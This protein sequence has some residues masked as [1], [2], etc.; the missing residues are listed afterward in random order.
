MARSSTSSFFIATFLLRFL[1]ASLPRLILNERTG[2]AMDFYLQ[3]LKEQLA[4]AIEG[5]SDPQWTSHPSGRWCA[6]EILEHL[7]L[8]YTGTIKGLER[9][10]AAGK[11]LARPS[12]I[13]DRLQCMLVIG[14]GY[15]PEGRKAPQPTIP[16]GLSPAQVR[17]EI[18]MR[19]AEMDALF[20]RAIRA[21]GPD[22]RL[23][24]HPII[25]PLRGSEWCKF[26][27]IHGR[28]H[29]RQIQRLQSEK[30]K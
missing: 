13:K 19:I 24:D 17:G 22:A 18:F 8:T 5:L 21:Y 23:L 28:H 25:G 2:R 10:L 1:I 9:C 12:T 26:H 4:N 11:P 27:W 14:W 6:A 7:Y 3:Q 16:K 15:L 30:A 29:V 20:E